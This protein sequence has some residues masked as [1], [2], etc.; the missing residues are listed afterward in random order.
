[1]WLHLCGILP[2]I[3]MSSPVNITVEVTCDGVNVTWSIPTVLLQYNVDGYILSIP[4]L[5]LTYMPQKTEIYI[6]FA[7]GVYSFHQD[8][9]ITVSANVCKG[10]GQAGSASFQISIG[11]CLIT[12]T[13]DDS[14]SKSYNVL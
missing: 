3:D 4:K 11:K 10:S 9:E 14:V 12:S 13:V 7:D 8:Y 5:N 2:T 6:P 1:M